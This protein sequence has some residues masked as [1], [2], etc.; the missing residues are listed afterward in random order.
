GSRSERTGQ[1]Q[2]RKEQ[3]HGPAHF[4]SPRM[5]RGRMLTVPGR[6]PGFTVVTSVVVRPKKSDEAADMRVSAVWKLLPGEL[7]L[8]CIV[9]R[10]RRE[11]PAW[12]RAAMSY[13]C[14]MMKYRSRPR[15]KRSVFST[16]LPQEFLLRRR[17]CS[18]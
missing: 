12:R 2:R 9:H 3:T 1:Q 16:E 5:T 17:S 6:S 10:G 15:S 14:R 8:R 7:M 11:A 13:A 18:L 4:F